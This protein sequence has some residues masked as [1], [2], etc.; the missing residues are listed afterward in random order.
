MAWLVTQITTAL[1]NQNGLKIPPRRPRANSS[2]G[3][4]ERLSKS[5]GNDPGL[6]VPGERIP[7]STAGN[8]VVLDEI[9]PWAM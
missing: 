5:N 1:G 6:D 3:A 4:V 7:S 8:P 9:E 2:M